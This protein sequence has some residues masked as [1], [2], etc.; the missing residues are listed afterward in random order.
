MK[1]QSEL[2]RYTAQDGAL[3]E[4]RTAAGRGAWVCRDRGCFE[5]AIARRAFHRALRT[6]VTPY[7]EEPH[8]E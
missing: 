1:P 2:V 3:V 5:R 4:S 6:N 7:T 8:A